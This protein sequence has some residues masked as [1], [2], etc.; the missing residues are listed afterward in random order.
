M[1][2]RKIRELS[3]R[4]RL[5]LLTMVANGIGALAGCLGFLAYDMRVA[6]GHREEELQSAAD[7]IGTNST[8]ALA[9]DDPIDAAKLLEALG[10]RRHIRLGVL[11]RS[12]GNFFA[13]YIRSDLV[14][15][16]VLPDQPPAGMVWRGDLLAYSSPVFLDGQRI[17]SLYLEDDIKDLHERL[18]RLGQITLLIA[19]GSGLIVYCLTAVLQRG[20]TRPIQDLAVLARSIT[21]EKSYSLRAP[22]LS[23]QELRQLG[24]DFN[25]M[26]EEIERRDAALSEARDALELRVAARTRELETEIEE[27]RRAEEALRHRTEFL[28]TLMSSS[29][30]ATAVGGPDGRFHLINS[31]FEKLFGYQSEEAIGRKVDE[32]IYPLSLGREEI[33]KRL[34]QVTLQPIHETTIRK[35]KDGTLVDVEVN[36]VPVLIENGE[37]CVL[38]VYLDVSQRVAAEKALRESEELFR[39]VSTLAPVGIFRLNAGG[40]VVYG[41]QRMEEITGWKHE[42]AADYGYLQAV[43]PDDREGLMKLLESAA[44]SDGVALH[45]FRCVTPEGRML[46]V[47]SHFRALRTEDRRLTGFIGVLEDVTERRETQ[48]RLREAKEAAE[49]ASRA[50][51]EFLANMS[52]EIRTPMNGILGMTELALDTDL[53]LDQREYLDMV[54]S[55]AE[56]LLGIINDILDFSKIETGRLELESVPFSLLDCIESALQPI[57]LRAQQKGLEVTWA[58]LGDVPEALIGDPSRLRQILINLAGNAVKFTKEGEVS[59]RAELLSSAENTVRIRFSVS[60]TGIGIP[61]EMQQQIFDAFSQADSSTTREFGGTGLGLSISARLIQLMKGEIK[62]DSTPG[63]GSTFTFTVPFAIGLA[64]DTR[65]P[66]TLH[67]EL[68]NIKVLAVDDNEINRHLLMRLLPMWG[69]QPIC[70]ENG[71]AALELF[72][73]SL[74]DGAPFPLVLLDQHMPGMSGC[75]VAAKIRQLAGKEPVALVILSSAPGSVDQATLNAL[76]IERPLAKPLRRAALREAIL[77]A[78]KPPDQR[79]GIPIFDPAKEKTSGLRLLL[80][81]DNSV[82][83]KLARSLL[84]KMGH[85]VTL[86]LNGREAVELLEQQQFDLVLMDIQMPVMGGVEATRMIRERERRAGLRTPIIALTAHAMKGDAEKYLR[87]GMDGYVSKPTNADFLRAEIN[88]LTKGI[89]QVEKNTMTAS[90]Q[91][92]SQSE[93]DPAE[94]L[95]RVENDRELLRD[96]LAIFKEELPR[97]LLA[98][99]EAVESNDDARIAVVAHTLKGMLLNVAA[100]RAASAAA[101][102]E[103]LARER[104]KSE[105]QEALARL[106]SD[107]RNLLP[108][109]NACLAEVYP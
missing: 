59:V 98:I 85:H 95:A 45:S 105:Y 22:P 39:T 6:R 76:Q 100:N 5:L 28:N 93:I 17:G 51:S 36:C 33:V 14:G 24:A 108:Q 12:D 61:K 106:E 103:K 81:E 49:A 75:E 8:A 99:R 19:V 101:R 55:S 21:A 69:L 72:R 62:L 84:E 4:R 91:N 25:H 44:Q 26:L 94:L 31:A 38:A 3:L 64:A 42:Q 15:K 47:D 109:L 7:L 73:K 52:H 56:S 48:E 1:P 88:R 10:T 50:K 67:P 71:T 16:I 107:A 97:H 96:L 74:E 20:I 30:L 11:Y 35:K 54:K 23:G 9:F 77:H 70:A 29:P 58:L 86:A 65:G 63:R 27:R 57:A 89:E 34:K 32:L 102:L 82:N 90:E 66:A 83:Q 46:W 41:N 92:S 2:M 40:R 68:L 104:R 87:A 43:H 37:Q 80:A 18:R 13:S 79:A 53:S 78:L 60:D